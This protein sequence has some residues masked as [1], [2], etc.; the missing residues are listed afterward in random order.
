MLLFLMESI[1]EEA[2]IRAL[3]PA[4]RPSGN[5]PRPK[6]HNRAALG[7]RLP[8]LISIALRTRVPKA[9]RDTFSRGMAAITRCRTIVR[10]P[11]SYPRICKSQYGRWRFERKFKSGEIRAAA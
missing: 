6:R 1:V 5:D 8:T 7:D 2:A 4:E 9:L 3:P 10:R 11:H